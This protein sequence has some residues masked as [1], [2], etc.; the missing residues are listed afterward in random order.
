[1]A[2]ATRRLRHLAR[3]LTGERKVTAAMRAAIM[4]L[5][6]GSVKALHAAG[7]D[8]SVLD[9]RLPEWQAALRGDVVPAIEDVFTAAWAATARGSLDPSEY[10]TRHLESVWNRLVG[11]SDEVFDAMRTTLEEGRQAGEH[12]RV[13][14]QRVDA[15]LADHQRWTNRAVTVARTEVIAANNAGAHAAAYATTATLG[16]APGQ[17]VKEWLS[18]HDSRTRET[19]ADADG[20]QVMG[21]DTP[22]SVGGASLAYPGDPSGPGGEVINCRCTLLYVMPD[23]PSYAEPPAPSLTLVPGQGETPLAPA[24]TALAAAA[25]EAPMSRLTAA[26][27]ATEVHGD[28]SGVAVMLL[29]AAADPVQSIG[30]EAKHVTVLQYGDVDVVTQEA[31]GNGHYGADFRSVLEHTIAE[32]A[33]LT[34]PFTEQVTGV[35]SLGDN[36]ARVW[37]LPKDGQ[38]AYIEGDLPDYESEVTPPPSEYPEYLP[39]VTIGYPDPDVPEEADGQL[40]PDVEDA[41]AQ[42]TSITFDRLAV[43]WGGEQTEYA[44]AGVASDQEDTMSRTT[45][46]TA[47]AGDP[48]PRQAAVGDPAPTLLPDV[49]PEL[50]DRFYGVAVVEDSQ[51][52]DGRVFMPG[53]L[54]WNEADSH[55]LGW[56]V[57]DA[58][59]HDG[60][61]VCGRIDA[62][63]RFGNLIGYTGTW[64]LDGAGW[65]VRRLVEGRFVGGV[66]VDTDDFA[67]EVVDQDG[68]PV[69]PM[70]G[71]F[72][73]PEDVVLAVTGA[74][75]RSQVVCRVPAFTEAFI[76][77]GEPPAGWAGERPG[78]VVGEE[79]VADDATEDEP[80]AEIAEDAAVAELVAAATRAGNPPSVLPDAADFANPMF[81]DSADTDPRLVQLPDRPGQYACPITITDDGRVYGHLAAW[82]TC[83]VGLD[84][85]VTPPSSRYAYAHFLTGEVETN[86]GMVPVGQITMG[87]GHAAP[88]LSA[89]QAAAHYDNT[90]TA[91]FD[92]FVG[93]DAHGIWFSGRAR[94]DISPAE[95]RV[96]RASGAVSGDW[97]QIGGGLE[98]VAVLSVNVPGFPVPRLSVAASG[99]RIHSLQAAGMLTP[100]RAREASPSDRAA[101]VREVAAAVDRTHRSRAAA[102]RLAAR[103]ARTRA[104]RVAASLA[105]ITRKG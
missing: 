95:V 30:P 36:G 80:P 52:G 82:G 78:V 40:A 97:R 17:V 84:G 44:L 38:C 48:A 93:E 65:E 3:I 59:G 35:E 69:D 4:L 101:F 98:L 62:Y 13:L 8:T 64:D 19:H 12:P 18:T 56:Q 10:A 33:A 81:G 42:V 96:L 37:M 26:L 86:A 25:E 50:D 14:A 87:T 61:V 29:P 100:G 23:D 22:F 57:Q 76:A 90:G 45:P 92:V 24:R 54:T 94:A 11:V 105:R 55:P 7:L 6:T 9:H 41:A 53:S 46:V 20:Q 70:M 71:M 74:R 104:N 75:I 88:H 83:H 99:R 68:N 28:P 5:V 47:A 51:T 15:L 31:D 49:D 77:N 89:T 63:M 39:H 34:A 73:D 16:Y 32:Y 79:T 103:R 27:T 102:D 72:G 91:A 85:C 2:R 1:M 21:L 43:W 58:P 60:S 66:S 67:A